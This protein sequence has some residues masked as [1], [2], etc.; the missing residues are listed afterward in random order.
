MFSVDARIARIFINSSKPYY[1]VFIINKRSSKSTGIPWGET[2]S[3]PLIVHIPLLVA[4][5]T[6]GANVDS[7]ALLRKVKHSISSIWT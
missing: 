1:V 5:T 2:I 3:V 4:S 6:M 7:R